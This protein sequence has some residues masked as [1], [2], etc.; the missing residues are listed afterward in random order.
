LLVSLNFIPLINSYS[1]GDSV[2]GLAKWFLDSGQTVQQLIEF[3]GQSQQP[4]GAPR[5]RGKHHEQ[6][7][8]LESPDGSF[9]VEDEEEDEGSNESRLRFRVEEVARDASERSST[10]SNGKAAASN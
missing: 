10:G 4:G 5:K 8:L 6:G 2:V 7:R 3:R 1:V 9:A